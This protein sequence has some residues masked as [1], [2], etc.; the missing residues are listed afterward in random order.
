MLLDSCFQSLGSASDVANFAFAI[1][2]VN[3]GAFM[4]SGYTILEIRWKQGIRL[5]Y[6]AQLNRI[7]ATMD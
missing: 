3:N 1:K 2:F 7:V 5:E 6:K 4:E